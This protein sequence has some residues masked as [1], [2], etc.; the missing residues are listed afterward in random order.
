MKQQ[1][2]K[3]VI[4]I[5]VLSVILA[6]LLLVAVQMDQP[7]PTVPS[8]TTVPSTQTT[9]TTLPTT[10][11]T[12]PSTAP[13]TEPPTQPPIVKE[14]TA[15]IGA[16]GDILMHGD[17]IKSGKIGSSYNY[18][19]IFTHFASYVSALDYAVANMEGTLCG[20][21]NGYSYGGYP[22]FNA[23]DAIAASLKDAGFDML[24]T[25]NNHSYDTRSVGFHRTQ[26]VIANLGLAHTG[27]VTSAEDDNF[28]V[29]DLNGIR[30]GMICYTY[31]TG[32]NDKTGTVGLN[33]IPLSAGDEP[34]IN[35]FD[36]KNLDSFYQELSG[37]LAEM[38]LAGAEATVLFIHWGDEYKLTPNATQ[39][40]M[41]QKLCDLGIDVI[42]GGHAHVV[43]P[44]ELLTSTLDESHK[45]VCLYSM[46]NAVSNQRQGLISSIRTAHTEDGVL[47]SVRFAKYSDGTVIVE[48]VE[49]LPIWVNMHYTDTAK[50]YPIL[51]LDKNVADWQEAFG[52]TSSQLTKAQASYDRTMAIVGDGLTQVQTWCADNQ[53]AVETALGVSK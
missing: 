40:E 26:E 33:T 29:A 7:D 18:S 13:P 12:Q 16:V 34:L 36:Y 53:A 24:L 1:K 39:K 10:Q 8:G 5:V 3:L 14:S 22:N 46:G 15:S 30:I 51:P 31:N 2:R 45:T 47:M 6:G 37:Q 27:T 19:S 23:P 9:P 35:S 32:V 44:M 20:T 41:A 42:F 25:A 28:I 11:P 38:E 17:V 21:D 4:A 48:A 50:I 49:L 52:L 43:E